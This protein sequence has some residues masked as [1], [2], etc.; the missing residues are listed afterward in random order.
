M[1]YSIEFYLDGAKDPDFHVEGPAVFPT[2]STG[3][4]IRPMWRGQEEAAG[5]SPDDQC[6]VVRANTSFGSRAI[7]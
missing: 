7:S 5:Y 2:P 6:R 4:F 3:D 1:K